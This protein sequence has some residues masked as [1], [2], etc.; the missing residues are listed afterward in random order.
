MKEITT[1]VSEFIKN[2]WDKCKRYEPVDKDT[3]IG[4]PYPYIVPTCSNAFQEMYY[5][6]T[7]FTCKGLVLSDRTEL[8]KS[9]ADDMAFLINKYGFML[10]GNRT[11]YLGHSQ[12]PYFCMI[13]K[14]VFDETNDKEWLAQMYKAIEKEYDFWQRERLAPIGLNFYSNCAVDEEEGKRAYENITNRVRYKKP[15]SEYKSY[16]DFAEN[17][18]AECESGWDFNPRFDFKCKSFAPAD[19]NSNLYVYEVIMAQFSVILENGDE[20]KWKERAENRKELMNKY[21]WNG[22][23]FADYNFNE[24][25]FST[26]FSAAAFHPLWAGIASKEQAE[27]TYSQLNRIEMACGI[28]ACENTHTD[29]VYQWAYPNSWAPLNYITV[30][31]LDRYGFKEAALRIADKYVSSIES[32]FAKTN[33]LWEKYNATDGSINVTNEYEMPDMLGWTAG[34]YLSCKEYIANNQSK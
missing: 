24:N 13:V 10:N 18:Y 7:Y 25:K 11:Y 30:F 4:M 19:L 1:E 9:C 32:I 8:A 6:D 34:V 5:W 23:F 21:L 15:I 20:Q 27:S 2:N 31:G 3:L 33:N 12:P 22:E 17:A 14:T 28:S 29:F 16:A 26:V